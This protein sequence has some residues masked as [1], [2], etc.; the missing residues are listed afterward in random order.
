MTILDIIKIIKI[1][2]SEG[3]II[4]DT[5]SLLDYEFEISPKDF[6][7]YSKKD[8]KI[9]NQRGN[10]NALTNA[11]RSI[12]CQTDKIFS[13]LGLNPN[14][15]P[16]VIEEFIQKSK[17]QT[18]KKDIPTR[19]RF[20][21][22]MNFAPAEIIAKVRTLRHKLEHYYKEPTKEEV[23]NAIELAELF[24]LA[25][26]SKL[27][28]LWDFSFTDKTK[29]SLNKGRLWNSIYITYDYSQNLFDIVGFEGKNQKHS[30][31][32]SNTELEYYYILKI[33][34]SFDYFEDVHEAMVDFIEY[35]GHPIPLDNIKM[36]DSNNL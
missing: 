22:A 30:I 32:I 24:L 23:S 20:L 16:S 14:N 8:Y 27:K 15:F 5:G 18:S 9:D 6:L 29:W 17:N 11:K 13:A 36:E 19:L 28:S 33:A 21:Q 3:I 26:D 12:D 35:I 4:P 25:T 31:S 1:D 10:I 2:F 7:N 34:T